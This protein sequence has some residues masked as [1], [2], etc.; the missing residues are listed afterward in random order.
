MGKKHD[1]PESEV[2]TKIESR[3]QP[4]LLRQCISENLSADAMMERLG[5]LH[6]QTLRKHLLRL[7]A[8]D[9]TFY[10][11]EA[12]FVRGSNLP[13]VNPKGRL[14]LNLRGMVIA[15]QEVA[16]GDI[17]QVRVEED[18]IVLTRG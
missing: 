6:K 3:Y 17:F 16:D 12:L 1:N 2:P 13:K 18:Q 11:V 14:T 7:M 8:E 9:K 4:G 15:G 10:D 5:I